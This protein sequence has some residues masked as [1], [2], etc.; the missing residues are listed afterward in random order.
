MPG[1]LCAQIRD[2]KPFEPFLSPWLT[3]SLSFRH[4]L[5]RVQEL[6]ALHQELAARPDNPLLHDALFRVYW[7]MNYYDAAIEHLRAEARLLRA[8]AEHAPDNKDLKKSQAD[9]DKLLAD[10]E[11]Q[12]QEVQRYYELAAAGKPARVQA[13]GAFRPFGLAKQALTALLREDLS[14][15]NPEEANLLIYLHLTLG[16][17]EELRGQ[18]TDG[19]KAVLGPVNY[20]L[21]QVLQAA[22][23][24]DYAD[25]DAHLARVLEVVTKP[26]EP[27]LA[28]MLQGLTFGQLE[29]VVLARNL[30]AVYTRQQ[31]MEGHQALLARQRLDDLVVLRGLLALDVG[32]VA[33]AAQ[34]FRAAVDAPDL[35]YDFESRPIA[36]RYLELLKQSRQSGQ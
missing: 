26:A 27:P 32:N 11:K 35:R 14:T 3:R 17:A 33:A 36:V 19:Q 23:V 21:Y 10:C 29:P 6:T 1:Q 28:H 16:K 8:A 4:L 20:E 9:V 13:L 18:F 5:R 22:A 15:L 31:F 7:N 24:G 2:K 12:L 25:A 34:H 30:G